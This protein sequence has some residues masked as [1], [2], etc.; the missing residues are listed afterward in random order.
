LD[1]QAEEGESHCSAAAMRVASLPE[2]RQSRPT[3]HRRHC[4]SSDDRS[5]YRRPTPVGGQRQFAPY[6]SCRRHVSR[7]AGSCRRT[8]PPLSVKIS[9]CRCLSLG[10]TTSGRFRRPLPF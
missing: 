9:G 8:W 6:G 4:A 10:M 5:S 7:F 1:P 2:M 3:V